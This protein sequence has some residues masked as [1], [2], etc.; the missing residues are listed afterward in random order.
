MSGPQLR[1]SSCVQNDKLS[2]YSESNQTETSPTSSSVAGFVPVLA[3]I[4]VT[5]KRRR[6]EDFALMLTI[7]IR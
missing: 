1:G 6:K 4:A 3:R 7:G 2:N 5:E